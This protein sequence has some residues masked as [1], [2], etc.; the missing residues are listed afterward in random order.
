M[1]LKNQIAWGAYLFIIVAIAPIAAYC[2]DGYI[3]EE[4]FTS[5]ICIFYIYITCMVCEWIV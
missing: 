1:K 3:G 4:L 2:K 5:V